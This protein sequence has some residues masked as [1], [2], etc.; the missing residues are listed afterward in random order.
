MYP[1]CTAS[2][3]NN[4]VKPTALAF[5]GKIAARRAA[6]YA[7]DVSL[8]VLGEHDEVSDIKSIR[9]P[10]DDHCACCFFPDLWAVAA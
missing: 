7:A 9:Q 10:C 5:C 6:A 2:R 8:M 3:A 1:V 4:R